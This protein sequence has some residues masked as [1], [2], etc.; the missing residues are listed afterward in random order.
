MNADGTETIVPKSIV[1]KD[2]V[3]LNVS[4]SV[5]IKI[6]D[7]S[8]KFDDMG[9]AVWAQDA[10]DF[11]TARELFGGTSDKTFGPNEQMNRAML[12]TVL[13]RLE[14]KPV[15]AGEN[16]F[17]D[18]QDRQYYTEAVQWAFENSIVTGTDKGFEPEGAITREQ[19]AAILYRYMGSPKTE[20]GELNFT[21][22]SNVSDWAADAMLWAT[23]Q[24][25]ITGKGVNNLDPQGNATRAE[26]ATMLMRLMQK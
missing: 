13:H 11:V 4:K 21:D 6:I 8:K 5:T 19:L 23:Q 26:V 2:G 25:I 12:V 20:A 15:A 7:N 1:T 24:G 16:K 3:V 18:V 22:A 9:S 17:A 14:G 10:V